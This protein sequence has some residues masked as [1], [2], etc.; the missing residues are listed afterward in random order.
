[1][2]SVC[3]DR[4]LQ[5]DGDRLQAGVV[6]AEAFDTDEA[7]R[8]VNVICLHRTICFDIA[9]NGLLLECIHGIGIIDVNGIDSQR[10]CGCF[11][12]RKDMQRCC[13]GNHADSRK[14]NHRL[15]HPF[16]C[17]CTHGRS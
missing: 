16:F 8:S 7:G 11:I 4:G 6:Q 17:I 10:L 9:V 14:G 3:V 1:M 13:Q 15:C 2:L 5:G 12:C